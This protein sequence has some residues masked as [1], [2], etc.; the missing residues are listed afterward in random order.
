MHTCTSDGLTI[1][2]YSIMLTFSLHW[3]LVSIMPSC[4]VHLYRLRIHCG[5]CNQVQISFSMTISPCESTRLL[6]V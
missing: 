1:V 4:G 6:V 3:N 2:V 5:N